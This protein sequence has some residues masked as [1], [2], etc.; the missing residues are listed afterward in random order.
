MNFLTS[1]DIYLAPKNF[2]HSQIKSCDIE[3]ALHNAFYL[4]FYMQR[5]AFLLKLAV[6]KVVFCL[7]D[8]RLMANPTWHQG[9]SLKFRKQDSLFTQF[10]MQTPMLSFEMNIVNVKNTV[11]GWR[12]L[13]QE[14]R[15]HTFNIFP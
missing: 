14:A 5:I 12:N 7:A 11:L 4:L 15:K 8:S 2:F 9:V 10:L 13:L 6:F 3:I 1:G